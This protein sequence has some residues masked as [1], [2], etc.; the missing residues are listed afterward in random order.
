[1]QYA[2]LEDFWS[3]HSD[4]SIKKASLEMRSGLVFIA[5]SSWTMK[6]YSRALSQ[7]TGPKMS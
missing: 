7:L 3:W 2:D 6:M 4:L 5:A 1:M